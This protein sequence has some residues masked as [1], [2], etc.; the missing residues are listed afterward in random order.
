MKS[1]EEHHDH[2]GHQENHSKHMNHEI[3][4]DEEGHHNHHDH[5]LMNLKSMARSATLHCLTGCAVGE[6][7]GM[8]IGLSI[9]LSMGWTVL[10]SISLAFLFGYSFSAFPL[11]K[12]G[13]SLKKALT[14]VLAADTLSIL[15]MEIFENG[16]MMVVPGAMTAGL[17][18][19]I[20]WLS[21]SGAL[22]V[23]YLVAYPINLYLLKR[24]EGHGLTH[25]LI[26]HHVMDNRPL[27]Y[28]LTA[29]LL[30]GLVT[31]LFGFM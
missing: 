4:K 17:S 23:G 29:F 20:F 30:G 3:H 16:F 2:S 25:D 7:V 27:V 8:I 31:A 21:M 11:V 13:I 26:G 15:S 28:G 6:I 19:P 18:N 22:V 12:A 1:I 14:T 24:G 9:G 5:G 10:L